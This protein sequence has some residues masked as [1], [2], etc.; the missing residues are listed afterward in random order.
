ML[1]FYPESL[2]NKGEIDETEFRR[3]VVRLLRYPHTS[4]K[5]INMNP[6]T[7][8]SLICLAGALG[9][10]VNALIS[11]NG[12]VLPTVRRA[13]WC[14]G[15]LAN[16]LIGAFAAFASWSFYGSGAGVELGII[17]EPRAVLSLKFSALAGAFLVGVAG[18]KWIT[19]EVDKK[20]LKESVKIAG[21]KKLTDE[22][23]EKLVEGPALQ[24]LTRVEQA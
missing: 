19:N 16:I 8:A 3:I 2:L 14:P 6:W 12:F 5:N 18:A 15:F 20:L 11:D 13:I 22:E 7:C 4:T 9:G 21:T 23:C 1:S 17:N 24:V 10:A